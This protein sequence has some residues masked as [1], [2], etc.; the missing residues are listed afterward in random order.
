VAELKDE[1]RPTGE[2]ETQS[3]YYNTR[4]LVCDDKGILKVWIK[5]L[6]RDDTKLLAYSMDR[7]ELNCRSNQTRLMSTIKYKKG[8][9]VI[10]SFTSTAPK[11]EDVIPD[12]IGELIWQTVCHKTF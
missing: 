4:K 8:G 2:T 1:W 5:T 9:G 7:L 10:D 12:S 6:Q 3:F 11:W